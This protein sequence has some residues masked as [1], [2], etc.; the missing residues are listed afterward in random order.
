MCVSC[1]CGQVNDNHGDRRNITMDNIKS[2]AQAAGT[3]EQTVAQNIQQ[4][5]GMGQ[6]MG[7]RQQAQ[8]GGQPGLGGQS[9]MGQGYGS[10]TSGSTYGN[11]P[12]QG[13][14]RRAG[15]VQGDYD[16]PILGRDPQE[17]DF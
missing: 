1:G 12:G 13:G 10:S 9:G 14:Q 16:E 8:M 17:T 6:S 11:Q 5:V 15:G 3:D 7:G 2:A 4:G